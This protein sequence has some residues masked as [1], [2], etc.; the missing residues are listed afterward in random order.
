WRVLRQ[1]VTESVVVAAL[2]AIT[3]IFLAAI[4]T[5]L[6]MQLKPKA[7][8]GLDGSVFSLAT[9]AFAIAVAILSGA[10]FGLAPA[11]QLFSTR[12]TFRTTGQTSTART[13]L[14]SF[15][16]IAECAMAL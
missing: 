7:V 8:T 4:G 2:G 13:R 1:I 3:G 10:I 16:V 15:M 9:L 6:L 11:V 14:R 12:A 5:Q